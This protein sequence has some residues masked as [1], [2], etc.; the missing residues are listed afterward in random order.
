MLTACGGG[1]LEQQAVSAVDD[2]C[3]RY[4]GQLGIEQYIERF[5]VNCGGS[6]SGRSLPAGQTRMEVPG[7]WDV[8]EDNVGLYAA[9][10]LEHTL[11]PG[12]VRIDFESYTPGAWTSW[13][14]DGYEGGQAVEI[15]FLSRADDGTEWWRFAAS[16]S[17]N[18][19]PE[20]QLTLE[21]RLDPPR[22]GSRTIHEVRMRLPGRPSAISMSENESFSPRETI[23]PGDF[24]AI[25]VYAET[26]M[27]PAGAFGTRVVEMADDSTGWR[28]WLFE[29]IPLGRTPVP[30]GA[31][32]VQLVDSTVQMTM[33]LNDYG[34]GAE[35]RLTDAV[36]RAEPAEEDDAG[37]P[38]E[39]DAP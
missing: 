12:G 27:V 3:S 17:S 34:T 10:L 1:N 16:G 11:Y 7:M 5:G 9:D 38:G 13:D 21:L 20:E 6:E 26:V 32:Q 37:D 39:D 22:S 36:P 14:I 2:A 29:D 23:N 35:A 31:V 25:A 19:S 24:D 28:A 4:A 8:T 30:G 18:A 15:A 33:R